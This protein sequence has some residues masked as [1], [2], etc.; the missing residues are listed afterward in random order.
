MQRIL[1]RGEIESLD[2]TAIARLRRPERASVFA[3]RARRLRALAP[4]NPIGGY[5]SLM[6]TLAQA[7]QAALDHC[8]FAGPDRAG[9]D[10]AQAHGMPPLQ[11]MGWPRDPAWRGLLDGLLQ[12]VA[13][14]ADTPGAARAVCERLRQALRERPDEVEALADALLADRNAEVDSAAAPLVMAALQVYWTDLA[15][16]FDLQDMPVAS[17]FGVCPLCGSLPV[18]SVV[19]MG[20]Q[21]EGLR[22]LNCSLCAC[23]WHLVRVV[24]SQ[25]ESTEGVA[26]HSIEGGS[27]AIKAESCDHCHSYRKIF[28]QEKDMEVE[29]VADDLASLALDMLMGEAGYARASGNP[30]LWQGEEAAE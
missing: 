9:I 27:Q 26:Y 30:L 13:A 5:L 24:C 20:G 18:A 15:C 2:H 1:P 23:E 25:C 28:Y 10:R 16:R 8:A 14:A 7:Q 29:A 11:A 21:A 3:E 19:R 6:A 12:A 17:P 4:D 22:Y